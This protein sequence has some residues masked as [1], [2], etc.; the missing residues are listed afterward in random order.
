MRG[1]WGGDECTCLGGLGGDSCVSAEVGGRGPG[2][3]YG[4]LYRLRLPFPPLAF[5]EAEPINPAPHP[6]GD[7]HLHNK[8]ECA[9]PTHTMSRPPCCGPSLPATPSLPRTPIHL[10]RDVVAEGAQV[11]SRRHKLHGQVIILVKHQGANLWGEGGIRREPTLGGERHLVGRRASG[12]GRASWGGQRKGQLGAWALTHVI[13]SL[14][15]GPAE[16]RGHAC[17]GR[18]SSGLWVR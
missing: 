14:G 7:I 5:P 12:R 16:G 11:R 1:G 15:R 13:A 9:H 10:L 6:R 17:G 3:K 18:T 2:A 8:A 4:Q